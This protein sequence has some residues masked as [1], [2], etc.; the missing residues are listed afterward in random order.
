MHSP[1]PV[2]HATPNWVNSCKDTENGNIIHTQWQ[3]GAGIARHSRMQSADSRQQL[4]QSPPTSPDGAA[5]AAAQADA[6]DVVEDS[7]EFREVKMHT[8]PRVVER[9]WWQRLI[10]F[11]G[12]TPMGMEATNE[13]R[14]AKYT[15][16]TFLPINL[17][18][19]FCR[20]AN[21]YFLL[22]AVSGCGGMDS[23]WV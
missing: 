13:I 10:L 14:T 22:T 5:A 20:I 12:C 2:H 6:E 17:F 1:H 7:G 3:A 9:T 8:Q 16:V 4:G 23:V 15:L 21:L 18:E 11:C 19:Q